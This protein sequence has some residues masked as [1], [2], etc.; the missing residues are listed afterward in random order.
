VDGREPSCP[1]APSEA[2]TYGIARQKPSG[3][4]VVFPEHWLAHELLDG[5]TGLEIGAAAHNPFG[6]KTRNVASSEGAQFYA[7]AQRA[8]GVEPAPVDIWAMGDR[9]PVHDRGEDFILSSHVLEHLPN[10]I[11]AFLEWDRIVNDGGYVFMIVPLKGALV[12]DAPR[13]LTPLTHFIDCYRR[14]WTLD[15]HPTDGV[16]GGRMGHYHTFSPDSLTDVV[17]WM[18]THGLSDWELVAR[19]DV[20][21]KVGNGFTLAFRVKPRNSPPA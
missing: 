11:A 9:I 16:P 7:E 17:D 20:D 12:E 2:A 18:R 19:E 10:V 14:G 8:M 21:S 3:S 5:L 15:T 13:E 1:G 6:L 4:P